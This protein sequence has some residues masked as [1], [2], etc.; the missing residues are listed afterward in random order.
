MKNVLIIGAT[1][2]VGSAVRQTLSRETNANVTLFARSVGR[3]TPGDRETVIAGNAIKDAD[4]DSVID[5]QDAVFVAVSGNLSKFAKKIIG[6]MDRNNVSRLIF[7]T[8]MGI[9]D[10]IPA[11]LGGGNV[12]GNPMLRSYREAAD[13][14]EAS[15]LNYTVIR[16]GWFNDGPV[17]YEVTHKGEPFGGHDVSV[18]SIADMVK[19]L[20]EDDALD[21]RDSIGLNTPL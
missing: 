15:D 4:L 11:S 13:L 5:G 8:S 16:P 12:S 14:I 6:S 9:Y 18:S 20:I 21:S 1:G 17:D 10:E 3:I 2:T 7:I 19:N